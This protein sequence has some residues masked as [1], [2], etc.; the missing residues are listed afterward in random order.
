MA[1][2]G[3]LKDFGIADILQLIGQQSKTGTLVLKSGN[4]EID[5]LFLEGNVIFASEKDRKERNMLGALLTRAELLTQEQLDQ[6][7]N[8]QQRTLK[9]LGDILVEQGTVSKEQLGQMMRLQTTETLYKLFTWKSGSYEFE[10][11]DVDK[12]RSTFAPIRAESILLEGF[13]RVD[14][15]PALKKKVPWNDATFRTAKE[16]DVRDVP[17][18]TAAIEEQGDDDKPGPRHR[19]VYKLALDGRNVMQIVDASRVG[20]FEARKTIQQ[21]IEWGYLE[22]VPAAKGAALAKGLSRTGRSLAGGRVLLRLSLLAACFVATVVLVRAAGPA[23]SAA[24][25]EDPERR[26]AVSRVLSRGQA[27]RLESA[28]ELYRTEHGE[29]P[30]ALGQLVD[31]RVVAEDDLRYPFRERWYYRRTPQGFVLLPPLD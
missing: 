24:R 28:L 9:R 8:V 13:R 22:A 7:L 10:T 5:V 2:S 14:E 20:E 15:W 3:T 6:A 26:G 4:A 23:M 11:E 17:S 1:L 12:A 29:Y 19:L 30:A 31:A 25:A 16:L 18:I 27:V 21:L